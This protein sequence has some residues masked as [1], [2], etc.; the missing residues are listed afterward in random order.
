[1]NAE[2]AIQEYQCPGCVSGP[3]PECRTKQN[4][5]GVSCGSHCP[6]TM[7]SGIGTIF[8]GMERGFNRLGRVEPKQLP[9]LIF[10]NEKQF[11][12]DWRSTSIDGIDGVEIPIS[13]YS[14]MNVPCWKYLDKHGNTIVRGMSPRKNAPFIHIHLWDARWRIQCVEITDDL[15]KQMD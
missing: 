4:L 10:E 11:E 15:I 2:E 5:G 12:Q 3:Y 13:M 8:L 14:K 1:M 9:L 7:V 6:G